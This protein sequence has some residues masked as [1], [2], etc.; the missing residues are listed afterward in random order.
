MHWWVSFLIHVWARLAI[1][2]TDFHTRFYP[3][4]N[5]E[6]R[7]RVS[8]PPPYRADI[9]FPSFL[10]GRT[11][12]WCCSAQ[13]QLC[14]TSSFSWVPAPRSLSMLCS[15]YVESPLLPSLQLSGSQA[16]LFSPTHETILASAAL[17]V[18]FWWC[19]PK[20][21]VTRRKACVLHLL[22]EPALAGDSYC[23]SKLQTSFWQ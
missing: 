10:P 7:E 16:L 4:E 22:N 20:K 23:L 13:P 19:S 8:A 3:Q 6:C 2:F 1:L 14:A 11:G 18:L 15:S 12:I 21:H 9:T 17:I 5:T